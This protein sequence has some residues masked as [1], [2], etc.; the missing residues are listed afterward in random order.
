MNPEGE[1]HHELDVQKSREGKEKIKR[2][3]KE[4]QIDMRL[5]KRVRR[6]N[7]QKRK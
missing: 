5:V 7:V 1:S 2:K 4:R 6:F 3:W